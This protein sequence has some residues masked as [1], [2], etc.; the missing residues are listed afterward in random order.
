MENL[1]TG[2]LFSNIPEEIPR[3]IFEDLLS[4]PPLRVQRIVSAGQTTPL[5]EWYDSESDEWVV[6]LSGGARLLY[7][8]E[9]TVREMR[10]GDYVLIPA[11][12]R[13]RVEW[14]HPEEKT[15]WLAL[16]F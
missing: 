15:V 2:N 10:P 8:G 1:Q 5:D 4:R 16:H 12:R 9:S 13:H 7:E 6:L 3:E 14:T 11:H